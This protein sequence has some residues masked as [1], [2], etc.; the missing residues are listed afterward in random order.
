LAWNEEVAFENL[1][2]YLF[3]PT[4]NQN[5][6]LPNEKGENQEAVHLSRK[7]PDRIVE[8]PWT[9]AALHTASPRS[10]KQQPGSPHFA[11]APKSF[12]PKMKPEPIMNTVNLVEPI[13]VFEHTQAPTLEATSK[14]APQTTS[15]ILKADESA[16]PFVESPHPEAHQKTSMSQSS[17]ETYET[18]VTAYSTMSDSYEMK[19]PKKD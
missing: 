18:Y 11:Q 6:N 10:S 14:D 7:P 3:Y 12:H 4:D 19:S 8:R 13:Q 9:V 1:C 5:I 2:L 16:V 15:P 17:R